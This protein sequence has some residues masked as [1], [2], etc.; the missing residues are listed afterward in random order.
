MSLKTIPI[1]P[2]KLREAI[3]ALRRDR[4]LS[5][6]I[7]KDPARVERCRSD[8]F[9]SLITAICGQQISVV[10]AG[11]IKRRLLA[12]IGGRRFTVAGVASLS[13][14]DLVGCG[15]SQAKAAAVG[16]CARYWLQH[17]SIVANLAR[18]SDAE[19]GEQLTSIKG[20]GPWTADMVLIFGLGRADVLPLTDAGIINGAKRLFRVATAKQALA[21]LARFGPGWQPYRT[22]ASVYLWALVD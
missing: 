14:R 19:V 21:K 2:G 16:E 11:A 8:P 12:A 17:P 3:A 4:W 20:V 9:N 22:V 15:L 18:L 1:R 6:E 10:A 13:R 7:R 5:G